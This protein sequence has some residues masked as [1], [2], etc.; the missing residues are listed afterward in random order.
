MIINF[1]NLGGGG[2][3]GTSDYSQLTNKP[4]INGVTLNG[5]QSSSDLGITSE[6]L[7][8]VTQIP[9]GASVGDVYA[10]STSG[11][12]GYG[13]EEIEGG[14]AFN[15][16]LNPA[17]GSAY[18]EIGQFVGTSDDTIVYI[19]SNTDDVN[20]PGYCSAF[21][22]AIKKGFI[23]TFDF[24][25]GT[26]RV[27]YYDYD[28]IEFTFEGTNVPTLQNPIA[29]ASTTVVDKKA[30]QVEDLNGQL[31]H[32][33]YGSSYQG[34][35]EHIMFWLEENGKKDFIPNTV[36][37]LQHYYEIYIKLFTNETG[38]FC[39]DYSE[40]SGVTWEHYLE[41]CDIPTSEPDYYPLELTD[42]N[43]KSMYF[44]A[45]MAAGDGN[46]G[47]HLRSNK[48]MWID[49]NNIPY[50]IT[51]KPLIKEGDSYES[52][53]SLPQINGVEL[54]GNK[55]TDDLNIRLSSLDFSVKNL[56]SFTYSADGSDVS[57]QTGFVIDWDGASD[58]DFQAEAKRTY[59]W[60][61]EQY[62]NTPYYSGGTWFNVNDW[63][64]NNNTFAILPD[65]NVFIKCAN[66]GDRTYKFDGNY[67]GSTELNYIDSIQGAALG[68]LQLA[69]SS[70]EVNSM[71]R[72]DNGNTNGTVT[73]SA[74][75]GDVVAL[76]ISLEFGTYY[77]ITGGT[78]NG[79]ALV[80]D[81]DF[82]SGELSDGLSV[83]KTYQ[84]YAAIYD[85]GHNISIWD[86][87]YQSKTVSITNVERT[88]GDGQDYFIDYSFTPKDVDSYD[89]FQ[90]NG[91]T[92]DKLVKE[93]ELPAP[94]V[95]ETWIPFVASGF[96]FV[97]QDFNGAGQY[98]VECGGDAKSY[99]EITADGNLSYVTWGSAINLG[100]GIW[101]NT[102]LNG[103]L[104]YVYWWVK[105]GKVYTK[106]S[107]NKIIAAF[108]D[109]NIGTN[110]EGCLPV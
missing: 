104:G 92:W 102:P 67:S 46:Y 33:N 2:G 65:G 3:G 57:G 36:V 99:V 39:I 31:G 41:N 110:P 28:R 82:L 83:V 23:K 27:N 8:A 73:F 60:S 58:I 34:R 43:N 61:G 106:V 96:T 52:L 93:Y 49:N 105:D 45:W 12:I 101:V 70:K 54:K 6:A 94:A 38:K 97:R 86:D 87:T 24:D 89:A 29:S 88:A 19:H 95:G 30:V 64:S 10:I 40:D 75:T 4:S 90:Y 80:Q 79:V 109:D 68:T 50:G 91:Y 103:D 71:I 56:Q 55:S 42:P 62:L 17:S 47:I 44:K 21:G 35:Y 84:N 7:E 81:R 18:V 25:G 15:M 76:D 5:N 51:V 32:F 59:G 107:G 22:D 14:Y 48:S 13:W 1:A 66:T 63:V 26:A 78:I 9:S 85:L 20:W 77:F 72:F 16:S 11:Q 69:Q 100:N 108:K 98:G 37:A 74:S 53:S